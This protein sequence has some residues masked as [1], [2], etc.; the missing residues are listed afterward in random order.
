[1]AQFSSSLYPQTNPSSAILLEFRSTL[2]N[3]TNKRLCLTHYLEYVKYGTVYGWSLDQTLH[4]RKVLS[5][6]EYLSG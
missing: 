3:Y 5:R 6:L 1:M 4:A 2:K